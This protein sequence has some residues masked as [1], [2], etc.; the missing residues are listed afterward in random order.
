V[1]AVDLDNEEENMEEVVVDIQK[2]LVQFPEIAKNTAI[3]SARHFNQF[4]DALLYRRG[5][6]DC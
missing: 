1:I 3:M 5:G 2:L 6:N 4:A